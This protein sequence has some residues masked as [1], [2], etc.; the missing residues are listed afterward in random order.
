MPLL[1][2][3]CALILISQRALSLETE[4]PVYKSKLKILD[5]TS[6]ENKAIEE[7]VAELEPKKLSKPVILQNFAKPEISNTNH[8]YKYKLLPNPYL[9]IQEQIHPVPYF[10]AED[11]L[12]QGKNFIHKP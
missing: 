2:K 6:G 4:K 11:K 8:L 3:F 5:S 10:V 7:P 12:Q 9:Q 1:L